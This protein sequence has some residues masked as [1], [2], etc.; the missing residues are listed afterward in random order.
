MEPSLKDHLSLKYIHVAKITSKKS[1]IEDFGPSLEKLN[2]SV[3]SLFREEIPRLFMIILPD[4]SK[5]SD[6]I[7]GNV[8]DFYL[9]YDESS[10]YNTEHQRYLMSI[11][12]NMKKLMGV[13]NV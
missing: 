5:F 1:G 6:K 11:V 10:Y 4:N 8:F 3:L 2:D 9:T 13:P 7:E 12:D